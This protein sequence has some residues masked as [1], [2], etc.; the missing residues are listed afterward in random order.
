MTVH[1]GVQ[2]ALNQAL[3]LYKTFMAYMY[4]PNFPQV[5]GFWSTYESLPVEQKE[6][7]ASRK[8]RTEIEHY[9]QILPLLM[10][11][12]SKEIRNRHWLQV[13]NV[14]NCTFQLEGSIFKMAHLLDAG[15]LL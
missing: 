13:M 3:P 12:H 4:L 1:Y 8:L 5:S 10:K 9:L 2:L 6:W 14:A 15:L 7:D 11:L